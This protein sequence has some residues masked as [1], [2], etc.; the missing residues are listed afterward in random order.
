MAACAGRTRTAAAHR[1]RTTASQTSAL[2]EAA[3]RNGAERDQLAYAELVPFMQTRQAARAG[4]NSR[5]AVQRH[6]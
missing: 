2:V 6:R 3:T 4:I 5:H 1:Q